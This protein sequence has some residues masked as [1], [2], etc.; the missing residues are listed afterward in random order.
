[1]S[2]TKAAELMQSQDKIIKSFQEV[3]SVLGKAGRAQTATDPAPLEMFETVINLKPESAWRD[4]MTVDKL[5][6]ELDQALQFPAFRTPGPC[7]SRRASTCSP[8]ASARRSA[9]RCLARAWQHRGGG[10]A[11]GSRGEAGARTTSAY[12]ERITGG[13]YLNIEPDRLQLARYGLTT[14]ELQEVIGTALG[15]EMVTTTS[16]DWN[17]SASMCAIRASS[18]P[19]RR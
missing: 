18:D 5:I 12:A 2:V 14:G 4:G 19:A 17:V 3:E 15:G 1:M 8:P 6:A 10:A 13:Y 7:R 11:G 16:R 9:S